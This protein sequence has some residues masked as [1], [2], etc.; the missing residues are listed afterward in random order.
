MALA[1]VAVDNFLPR[2]YKKALNILTMETRRSK[3]KF[4]RKMADNIKHDL[5]SFFFICEIKITNQEVW[6]LL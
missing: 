4:E 2:H 1:A 5:K 3:E 6:Q